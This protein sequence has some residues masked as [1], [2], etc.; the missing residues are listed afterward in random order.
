M[1]WRYGSASYHGHS[2][3]DC[4]RPTNST[5]DKTRRKNLDSALGSSARSSNAS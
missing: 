1:P 4:Y 3:C 2:L 5:R